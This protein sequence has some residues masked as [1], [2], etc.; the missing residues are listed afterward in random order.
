MRYGHIVVGP[1]GHGKTTY[2]QSMVKHGEAI[3]RQINVVNLDPAAENV[4]KEG[5]IVDV[6]ELLTVD[7]VMEDAD[8]KLGPNGGLVFAMEQLLD[9]TEWLREKLGKR[10]NQYKT[11]TNAIRA[12]LDK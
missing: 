4:C 11:I 7:E 1:A 8:L 6:R 10:W 12:G 3:G 9:D 5:L 2:C